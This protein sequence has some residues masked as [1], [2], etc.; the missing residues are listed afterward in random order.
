MAS[1]DDK[2]E[3]KNHYEKEL[4]KLQI[5]LLKFQSGGR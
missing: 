5:E 2:K 4:R 1:K 3:Q